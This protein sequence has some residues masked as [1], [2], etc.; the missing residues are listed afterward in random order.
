MPLTFPD[1]D[2]RL[3]AVMRSL[4]TAYA[5]VGREH[6]TDVGVA[7]T[8]G[9]LLHAGTRGLFHIDPDPASAIET[10]ATAVGMDAMWLEDPALLNAK[11]WL[12]ESLA[13]AHFI[14]FH[15]IVRGPS[16]YPRALVAAAAALARIAP[17]SDARITTARPTAATMT[18][19]AGEIP[20]FV[21]VTASALEN[22]ETAWMRV[23]GERSLLH[24]RLSDGA[25]AEASSVMRE[26]PAGIESA[27]AIY[28]SA[29][30]ALARRLFET[31]TTG[32]QMGRHYEIGT[33]LVGDAGGL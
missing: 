32:G 4:P 6:V 2:P 20:V 31:I 21:T 14:Q 11:Q 22:G 28:E 29:R 13:G 8:D 7:G 1:I 26:T 16:R 24:A 15:S 25:S 9:A 18:F 10:N 27:T 5:V 3:T 17:V 12:T 23:V 19:I 33:R 30:R